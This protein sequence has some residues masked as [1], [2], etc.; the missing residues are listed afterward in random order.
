MFTKSE[1]ALIFFILLGCVLTVIFFPHH[2]NAI[3]TDIRP[4]LVSSS[5]LPVGSGARAM[6][7]GGAFLAIADEKDIL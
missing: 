4:K 3:I 7:V 2:L 1:N 5:F 6:G